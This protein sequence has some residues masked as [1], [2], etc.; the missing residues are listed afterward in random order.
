ML[1]AVTSRVAGTA[2]YN[3]RFAFLGNG[4]FAGGIRKLSSPSVPFDF[5]VAVIDGG[6]QAVAFRGIGK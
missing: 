2:K 6:H 4:S 5:A 1:S 3:R